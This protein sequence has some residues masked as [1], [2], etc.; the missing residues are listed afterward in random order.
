MVK[1]LPAMWE[2]SGFGRF[3]GEG[4]SNPLQYSWL[5]N[6]MDRGAWQ[7]I[8]HEAHLPGAMLLAGKASAANLFLRLHCSN[9]Q[10][11]CSH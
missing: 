9:P 5:E 7:F 8:V 1:N 6:S 3:P 11:L 10:F 2:T 4:H